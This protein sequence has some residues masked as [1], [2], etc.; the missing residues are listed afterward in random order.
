MIKCPKCKMVECTLRISSVRWRGNQLRC[1]KCDVIDSPTY[2]KKAIKMRHIRIM[3][4]HIGKA[5]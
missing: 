1:P 3:K 5:V 2:I 4:T